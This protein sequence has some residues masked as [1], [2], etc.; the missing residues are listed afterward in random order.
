LE[1]EGAINEE[2]LLDLLNDDLD[3]FA[4]SNIYVNSELTNALNVSMKKGFKSIVAYAFDTEY[5][6]VR[7]ILR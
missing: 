5:Y 1:K 7:A 2:E 3:L 6:N 4:F